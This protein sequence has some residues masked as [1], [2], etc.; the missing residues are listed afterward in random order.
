MGKICP[1]NILAGTGESTDVNVRKSIYD[2]IKA[3]AVSTGTTLSLVRRSQKPQ[4]DFIVTN[5]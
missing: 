4:I 2:T 5:K 1:A 3:K